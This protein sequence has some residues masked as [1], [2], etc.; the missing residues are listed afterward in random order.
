MN[1][2]TQ[3]IIDDQIAQLPKAVQEIIANI[4]LTKEISDLKEKHNLMLDQVSSLEIETR[5]V[6]IGLEPGED[7]VDNIIKNVG[8]KED[9]AIAVAED[10]NDSIFGKIRKVMME[11]TKDE[12]G[13]DELNKETILD[14]I[15]NPTPFPQII[16]NQTQTPEEKQKSEVVLKPNE[17][18]TIEAYTPPM[19]PT[20]SIVEQ[21]LTA[22]THIQPKEIQIPTS[23]LPSATSTTSAKAVDPYREP[24]E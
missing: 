23:K 18:K 19:M 12:S 14:E 22:P 3:K 24:T 8:L 20:K 17:T 4:D 13:E 2:E 16:Q 5:L 9:D 7:F 21:K 6:M 1:P 10:I 15:E 11:E